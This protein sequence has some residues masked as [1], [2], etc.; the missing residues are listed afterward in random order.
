MRICKSICDGANSCL[1]A[2]KHT[3]STNDI[4][5]AFYSQEVPECYIAKFV[6]EILTSAANSNTV[7]KPL[8][9][10]TLILTVPYHPHGLG[11]TRAP[12]S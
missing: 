8:M 4:N 3:D 2:I 1:N 9:V 7:L 5:I 10:K 11:G 12:L 6:G